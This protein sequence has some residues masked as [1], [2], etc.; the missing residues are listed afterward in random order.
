MDV[1]RVAE[2][3]GPELRLAD[4]FHGPLLGLSAELLS[5]LVAFLLGCLQTFDRFRG[6]FLRGPRAELRHPDPF[7][8]CG[9]FGLR[10]LDQRGRLPELFLCCL[11][12]ELGTAGPL[13]RFPSSS[14]GLLGLSFVSR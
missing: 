11:S 6:L 9:G 13:R 12:A 8:S 5:P 4:L 14:L 1:A 3:S 10:G 2:R 7:R